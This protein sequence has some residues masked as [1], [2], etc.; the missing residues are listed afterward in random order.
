MRITNTFKRLGTLLTMFLIVQITP[1]VA[2]DLQIL[3]GFYDQVN[4]AGYPIKGT[5][6]VELTKDNYSFTSDQFDIVIALPQQGSYD[7]ARAA[8]AVIPTGWELVVNS[9]QS[10]VLRLLAGNT[11]T[12]SGAPVNRRKDFFI[13]IITSAPVIDNPS[14]VTVQWN[15]FFVDELPGANTA[16]SSLNV[17]DTNLPVVLISFKAS[18]EENVALLSWSTAAE[19]NS[20]RFEIQRSLDGKSWSQIGSVASGGESKTLRQYSYTDKTPLNGTNL[21][22]LRMVDKDETFAFSSIKSVRFEELSPVA[23]VYPNP[24]TDKV[25]VNIQNLSS[26]KQISVVDMNGLAIATTKNVTEGIDVK[27]LSAGAYLLKVANNDGSSSVHKFL[28]SR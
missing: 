7:P 14:L 25:F 28:I 18:K 9:N 20:D 6:K 3:G 19:T 27:G 10:L 15:D 17:A 5:Y 2:Q 23:Y 24:S 21:Y 13:P 16:G 8:E 4:Y 22:R 1:G 12:G 26:V 11:Y